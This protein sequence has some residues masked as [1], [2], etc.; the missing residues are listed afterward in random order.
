MAAPTAAA[1]PLL[2]MDMSSFANA[3]HL[4]IIADPATHQDQTATIAHQA[5][6]A[7]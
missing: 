5:P 1:K 2:C 3:P 6:A 4:D 7:H